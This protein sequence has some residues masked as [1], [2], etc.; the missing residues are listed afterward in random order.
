MAT[1]NTLDGVSVADES[2]FTRIVPNRYEFYR[3]VAIGSFNTGSVRIGQFFCRTQ[4][5]KN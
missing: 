3:L 5:S 4:L 2:D 1:A